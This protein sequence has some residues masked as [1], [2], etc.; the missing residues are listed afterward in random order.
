LEK[1]QNS[2]TK[3]KEDATWYL[4]LSHLKTADNTTTIRLLDQLLALNNGF[5]YKKAQAL[6]EELVTSD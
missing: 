5:Y 4:A 3:Y 2:K 1:V 6:K